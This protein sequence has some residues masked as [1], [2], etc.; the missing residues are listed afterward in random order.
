MLFSFLVKK[1]FNL[2]RAFFRTSLVAD[3]EFRMNFVLLIFGE[4]IWYSTQIVLFEVLYKHTKMLAGWNLQ[5]M[6]VF[7]FLA[8]F[9]DSIYMILWD[10]NFSKFADDLRRGNLDLILTKPV[11]SMFITTSQKISISHLPCFFITASG[12][13]WALNQIPIGYLI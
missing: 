13:I 1:Y 5:Q 8:L 2:Y 7:I 6:R 9:V 11:N 4:F 12:L 3:L 10:T